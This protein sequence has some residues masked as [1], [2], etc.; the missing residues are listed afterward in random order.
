MN[1]G[2]IDLDK[3]LRRLHLPT[4][5][6]LYPGY[7]TRAAAEGWSHRDY[8]ALLIAE[9]VAHRNDTRIQKAARHAHFPFTKTIENFDFVFQSSL[10]RQQLGPYLGPEL[11]SEGRNL[12]LS[13][14]PGR[15]KTHLAVAIAYRAIQNGFTA[16]FVGA[17]ALIDELGLA[18]RAGKLRDATTTWVEPHVLV[19]DEIGYLNHAEDAANVLFGVVDQRYLA[20]KPMIFTTNKKLREWG[21]VLHDRDLAEVILDRVLERGEHIAL[22]GPSWR[23]K[24]LDPE[25]LPDPDGA[26]PE[27]RREPPP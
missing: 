20:R 15:G 22:G 3:L 25:T 10:R 13:G 6:R 17:S 27:S 2:D 7:A 5:R 21:Q 18:S 12:I 1:P 23:T 4:V 16:R 19:I 26:D 8:L 24:H 14:K 9:E 11:V